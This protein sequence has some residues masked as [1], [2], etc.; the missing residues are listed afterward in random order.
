MDGR[1]YGGGYNCNNGG[2]IGY[3]LGNRTTLG[4]NGNGSDFVAGS[5]AGTGGYNSGW[6]RR[7][8]IYGD[9]RNPTSFAR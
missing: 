5:H 6:P 2:G 4:T 3:T 1:G 7:N 9:F 8:Q